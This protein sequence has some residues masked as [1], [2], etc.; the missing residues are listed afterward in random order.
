MVFNSLLELKLRINPRLFYARLCKSKAMAMA[1]TT[2][3]GKLALAILSS[4]LDSK[5][6]SGFCKRPL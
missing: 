3:S 4:F 1:F 5:N 2:V 6:I